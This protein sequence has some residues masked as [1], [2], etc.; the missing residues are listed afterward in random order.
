MSRGPPLQSTAASPETNAS[1]HQI[2]TR[3]NHSH[4]PKRH[5]TSRCRQARTRTARRCGQCER[6]LRRSVSCCRRPSV[7]QNRLETNEDNM[8]DTRY[9]GATSAN[10]DIIMR[11]LHDITAHRSDQLYGLYQEKWQRK[12]VMGKEI[13]TVGS[14]RRQ[15]A[16]SASPC[17]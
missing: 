4:T 17:S 9:A 5:I 14:S 6:P 7:T 1:T 11:R 16:S 13:R 8:I 12:D 10:H 2:A 3:C 15:P